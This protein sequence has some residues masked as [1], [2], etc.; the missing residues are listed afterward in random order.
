MRYNVSMPG[1]LIAVFILCV[2]SIGHNAEAQ[3]S[4]FG[5]IDAT[6]ARTNVGEVE[7]IVEA[8]TYTPLF[9]KGR[10]EPSS[11]NLMR[12]VALPLDADTANFTYR[13]KL[14]G[15]PLQGQT[16][17]VVFPAPIGTNFTLEVTVL[18]NG[19]FWS[20]ERESI[21]LSNPEVIFYEDN[22]LRGVSETAISGDFS[23]IGA[24]ATVAAVPFFVGLGNQSRLQ[25]NW[26]VDN[27][28]VTLEDWR[29]LTLVRPVEPK[30]KYLVELN[31]FNQS[32]LNEQARN[33]FNLHLEI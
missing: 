2:L 17:T 16:Q 28:E 11:G 8:Y 18:N 4:S 20:E 12:A 21:A 13:W 10:A 3:V 24:E 25:G 22:A 29:K 15:R 14:N 6:N 32:N 31:I 1:K 26:T 33:S 5:T 19:V 9:Y 27:Q 7:V 30:A 23:L